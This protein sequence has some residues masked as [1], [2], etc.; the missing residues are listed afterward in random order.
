MLGI[1]IIGALVVLGLLGI[2]GKSILSLWSMA[3]ASQ[4]AKIEERKVMHNDLATALASLD[5]RKLQDFLVLWGDKVDRELKKVVQQRIDELY[6][7]P[8]VVTRKP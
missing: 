4:H 1:D 3:S 5:Y 7:E 6:I 8:N 2:G